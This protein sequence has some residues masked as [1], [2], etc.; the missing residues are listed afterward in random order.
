MVSPVGVEHMAY[1]SFVV[2]TLEAAVAALLM[3]HLHD[4]ASFVVKDDTSYGEEEILHIHALLDEETSEEITELEQLYFLIL[5]FRLGLNVEEPYALT[6]AGQHVK[7]L[8][9]CHHHILTDFFDDVV[10]QLIVSTE[11][12]VFILLS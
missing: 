7:E 10:W 12:D 6:V 9:L 5:S 4:M 1:S 2:C 8:V 3:A 11:R